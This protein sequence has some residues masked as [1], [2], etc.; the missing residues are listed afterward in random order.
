MSKSDEVYV[1]GAGGHAKVVV[2]TLQA[3]GHGV[4][5]VFDDDRRK[6]GDRLLGVPVRGAL[7]EL[8]RLPP[9]RSVIGIGDNATRRALAERFQMIDWMTV[10]HPK[11]EV[12]PSV[13]LGPGTVVF[14]GAIVQPDSVIGTHTII[15]TG[16]TIDH[17][18]IIGDY[19][20]IAP[21]THLA[22][23]VRLGE[24]VFLGI[25]S[26]VIPGVKI[27]RWTTVGAGGVIIKDLPAGVLAVG[28]PANPLRITAHK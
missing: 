24:G 21:G 13:Q 28:V 18:C 7:D 15:N 6:W 14:A 3:L 20:H 2:S 12:H 4:R 22:G 8:Q 1:L 27:G 10:V 25:G 16:A 17:D 5:A 19:V 9:A 23:G 11:A 26:V